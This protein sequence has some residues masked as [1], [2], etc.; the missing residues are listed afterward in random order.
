M[1]G[2]FQAIMPKEDRFFDLFARHARTLVDGS[3][4]LVKLFEGGDSIP[5]H[6]KAISDHEHAADDVIREVLMLVRRTFITP[7]DRS[8]ITDLISSMDDAIDEMHKTSKAIAMFEVTEFKPQMREMSLLIAKVARLTAEAIPMLRKM[9][10]NSAQLHKLTEQ[11]VHIE[12]EADDLHEDGMRALFR[13]HRDGNAM[14]FI[15]GREIYSHLERV[16]DRFEDVANEIQGI[17][18]DHS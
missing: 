14:N 9:G 5:E 18:I 13:E 4:S 15:V 8:A 6:C 16:V 7:F 10:S 2:W 11:I 3:D 1:L 17:V 12:A